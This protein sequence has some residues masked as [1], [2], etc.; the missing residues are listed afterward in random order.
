VT[1][2]LYEVAVLDWLFDGFWPVSVILGSAAV[3]FTVAWWN[4][5]DKYSS[6]YYAIG[7]GVVVVLFVIYIV[8]HFFVETASEQMERRVLEMAASVKA[9]DIRNALE[10]NLA[11]DFHAGTYHKK[12]FID[13]AEA[14]RQ[15]YDVQEVIIANRVRIEN[16]DR[17]QRTAEV[18]FQVKLNT[19]DGDGLFNVKAQ[20]VMEPKKGWLDKE[21]WKMRSFE[22]FNPFV[23][24]DSPLPIP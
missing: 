24:Q 2:L 15:R 12:D 5:R 13:K 21:V 4:T 6:K 14:L 3:A 19:P 18:F 11:D 7:V 8:L 9:K 17:N 1:G 20:F 16:L 23:E 10:K 22:Y